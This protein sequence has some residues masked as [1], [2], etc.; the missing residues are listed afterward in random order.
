M[1]RWSRPNVFAASVQE[2]FTLL[3]FYGPMIPAGPG[4]TAT[5]VAVAT[6][7]AKK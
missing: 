7:P 1:H 5:A 4:S 2:F 6:A 3:A